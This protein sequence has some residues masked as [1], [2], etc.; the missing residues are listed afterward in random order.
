MAGWHR[1][2][3]QLLWANFIGTFLSHGHGT[4]SSLVEVISTAADSTAGRSAAV[5]DLKQ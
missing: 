1:K 2:R 4:R 5:I 3:H